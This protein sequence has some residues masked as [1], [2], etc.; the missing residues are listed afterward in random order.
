MHNRKNRGR[1]GSSMAFP[2]LVVNLLTYMVVSVGTRAQV[3]M[4]WRRTLAY[5]AKPTGLQAP[6]Q[7]R[8]HVEA[9]K[10]LIKLRE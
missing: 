9:L 1:G 8:V 3:E 2:T 5:R 10:A 4:H 6:K 7:L